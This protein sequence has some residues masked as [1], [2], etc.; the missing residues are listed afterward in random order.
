MIPIVIWNT[1]F[2]IPISVLA[3][4]QGWQEISEILRGYIP[5]LFQGL[6]YLWAYLLISLLM[7]LVN[8]VVK[9]EIYRLLVYIVFIIVT[10]LRVGGVAFGFYVPLFLDR[11][12]LRKNYFQGIRETG[13]C[14]CNCCWRDF[15]NIYV[16]FSPGVFNVFV[17]SI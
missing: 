4:W 3:L 5:Y 9:E 13:N 16:F 7:C 6:W 17:R 8:F 2:Y 10:H 14:Y 11:I 1:I 12:L 15:S